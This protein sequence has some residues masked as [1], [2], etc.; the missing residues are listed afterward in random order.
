MSST[1][2]TRF[3]FYINNIQSP[4]DLEFLGLQTTATKT[5]KA[6][7][8]RITDEDGDGIEDMVKFN[9][10]ELDE[11]TDPLV[12]GVAEDINNTHHGNLPGHKNLEFTMNQGEPPMH[13]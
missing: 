4:E 7:K 10:D 2:S 1:I 5:K 8:R 12:F 9:H 3:S 13:W 6:W 11:F